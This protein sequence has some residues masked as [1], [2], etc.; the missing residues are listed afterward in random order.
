M[1]KNQND[2]SQA[3]LGETDEAE[4]LAR[5][6]ERVEKAVSTIQDLRRERDQLRARIDE[7]EGREEDFDRLRR[8]RGEIR[9]RI[10]SILSNLE[11]LES[12]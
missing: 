1:K 6:S 9:D 4:I 3:V 10:E 12:E 2:D 7:L 5:L 8:E 11:Q